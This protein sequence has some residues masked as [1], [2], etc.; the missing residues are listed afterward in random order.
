MEPYNSGPITMPG[1][2][3]NG[4]PPIFT[5][6]PGVLNCGGTNQTGDYD[7]NYNLGTNFN[8]GAVSL[9]WG[10][11]LNTQKRQGQLLATSHRFPVRLVNPVQ[12]C[13]V[14]TT[15]NQNFIQSGWVVGTVPFGQGSWGEGGGAISFTGGCNGKNNFLVNNT[16]NSGPGTLQVSMCSNVDGGNFGGLVFGYNSITGNGYGLQFYNNGS[17]NSGTLEWVSYTGGVAST[18][19]TATTP[20]GALSGCPYWV[21][22]DISA[23]C[24]YSVKVATSQAGLS[25]GFGFGDL[26]RG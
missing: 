14:T 13:S 2:G 9:E 5:G 21:E 8:G 19:S 17:S 4:G 12:Q 20:N 11:S 3:D 18:V 23:S 10:L 16:V 25:L 1:M 6:P 7:R 24:Q 26:Y 15:F 22:V